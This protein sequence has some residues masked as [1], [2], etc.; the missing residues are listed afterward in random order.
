MQDGKRH[1]FLV[2]YSSEVALKGHKAKQVLAESLRQ[3]ILNRS[4]K[5]DPSVSITKR[6]NHLEVQTVH[7]EDTLSLLKRTFGVGTISFVL[8]EV[9][10]S[11]DEIIRLSQTVFAEAV[12]GKTFA[13]RLKTAG[14]KNFHSQDLKEKIGTALLPY[15]KGVQLKHPQQEVRID[16]INGTAYLSLERIKGQGGF[17]SH[18][19]GKAIVLISGGFD[20]CVAAWM[21]MKRGVQCHF[22]FCNLAGN[23]YLRLVLQVTKVLVDQWDGGQNFIAVDFNHILEDLKK[24][25]DSY[26]QV[27]LKRKMFQVADHF[28]EKYQAD[29]IV[30]GESLSQVSSQTLKNL[31]TIENITHLPIL[32]PLIG[33]NKQEI[34]DQSYKI[35]TGLLSEHV[36]ERCNITRSLPTLSATLHET[37]IQE[38][39]M[40]PDIL[41]QSL[42]SHQVF[43]LEQLE[44]SQLRKTSLFKAEI[45]ERDILIDCQP[46]HFYKGCHFKGS[47]HID[48]DQIHTQCKHLDPEKTYIIYCTY[49]TQSAI[50]AEYLQQM[51][52]EAYAFEG[53]V[54]HL[55]KLYPNDIQPP[56]KV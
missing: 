2:R 10:G 44:L 24:V 31:R 55:K 35:G 14:V 5:Y 20:S 21:L 29:A 6:F 19:Q 30:T 16:W 52:F 23:A 34:I 53:G 17:P 40:N 54:H 3:N 15:A 56:N 11:T 9:K 48:F 7:P 36:K 1:K 43:D 28:A 27:I 26:R 39:Q 50:V 25:K 4:K 33:M 12:K 45:T 41:N 42:A 18:S 37:H 38:N 32:R 22:V 51:G 13:V 8:A 47:L 46:E 49:G